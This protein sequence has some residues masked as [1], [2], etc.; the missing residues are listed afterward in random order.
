MKT[1][2]DFIDELD[3]PDW[4]LA[5]FAPASLGD[6]RLNRRLSAIAGDFARHPGAPITQACQSHERI[7]GAYRFLENEA[8]EPEQIML[9]HRQASLRRLAREPVV[10]APQDTTTFNFGE[11]P[12]TQGLGPVGSDDHPKAQGLWLHST[13]AFTPAGLPLGLVAGQFWARSQP[14]VAGQRRAEPEAEKESARWR[15]GWT[16]CQQALNQQSRLNLWVN[17]ADME[18]DIYEVFA[19][20]LAQ[21]APRVELLIRSRHDRPLTDQEHRLWEHLAGQPLAGELQVRV[22][23]HEGRPARL[24]RLQIRFCAAEVQA[25]RSQPDPSPLTLWA[26]EAREL[27]PPRGVRP[28]RWRLVSTLPV[29][30]AGEAIEKVRWYT[31]RWGIEV[32]HKIVK[33]ICRAEDHQLETA[34]RLERA[35]MIDLV[36]AW[37]I[38]LLTQVG[39]QNPDLPACDYFAESEWKAL[40]CFIQHSR[41]VPKQAPRLG[42]MMEDIGRLGGFVKG[43]ST[44]HPGP[45]TLARGLARLNDLARMWAIQNGGENCEE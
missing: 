39:R 22:P 35:L 28:I 36:V 42:D 15:Q 21:P 12:A 9:G 41:A 44:P 27:H 29:T 18:G 2:E 43:K 31:V 24:A 13:L 4:A 26:V 7:E 14:P 45:L 16:A 25:P 37:R 34:L 40:H 11:W 20:A 33:N 17:I 8:V 30:T 19:A 3:S 23:R 6:R 5:E 32:F 1:N 10:L 38:Q